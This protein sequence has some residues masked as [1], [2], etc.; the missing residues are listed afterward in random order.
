MEVLALLQ[1]N[2]KQEATNGKCLVY[3]PIYLIKGEI[4]G[5]RFESLSP[6]LK[7]LKPLPPLAE[8]RYPFN[9]FL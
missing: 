9:H 3:I 6:P 2:Q 8:N 4:E 7:A 1:E 5:R